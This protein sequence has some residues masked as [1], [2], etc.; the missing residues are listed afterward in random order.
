MD[1]LP[2]V[3]VLST[4]DGPPTVYVFP[5]VDGPTTVYVFPTVGVRPAAGFARYF[6]YIILN[7]VCLLFRGD[8]LVLCQSRASYY[9]Y[10][11]IVSIYFG[12][13]RLSDSLC[14]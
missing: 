5:T 1:G 8:Q 11:K 6:L 13:V 7:I 14:N 10:K 3:Y 12:L 2:T 9:S 4:V